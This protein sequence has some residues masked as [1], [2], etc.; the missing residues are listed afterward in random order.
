MGFYMSDVSQALYQKK[1]MDHYHHS[2]YRGFLENADFVTDAVSPSCGDHVIF[3]GICENSAFI[4]LKFKGEGSILGQAAASLLCEYVIGKPI[5]VVLAFS[6]N[7]LVALL[8]LDEHITLG[9]TRLRTVVFALE[10]LQKGV[11]EYVKS[12]SC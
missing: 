3:T 12:Q 2:L 11:R 1:I 6:I 8:G 4:D 10:T 9:P 7:E 5:N